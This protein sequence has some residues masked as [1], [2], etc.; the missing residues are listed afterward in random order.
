MAPV[1]A[2]C[3]LYPPKAHLIVIAGAGKTFLTFNAVDHVQGLLENTS[4]HGF[5]YF[6]CNRNEESRREPLSVL[7]SLVRQVST[8][9]QNP[10]AIRKTVQDLY[11]SMRLRGSELTYDTCREQLLEAVNLY[12]R[13]TLVLDALDEC[14]PQSRSRIAE[15]IKFLLSNSRKPVKVFVSSRPDRDIR[16]AFQSFANIE[17]LAKLVDKDIQKFIYGEIEKYDKWKEMPTSLQE[18]IVQE[19]SKGSDGM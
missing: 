18:E 4:N 3:L 19:L 15:T 7:R 8:A 13:T 16:K 10:G 14:D 17:I 9:A 11:R 5:A 1:S 12:E 6:Y 2:L